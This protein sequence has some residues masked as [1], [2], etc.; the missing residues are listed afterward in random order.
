MLIYGGGT[1][2]IGNFLTNNKGDHKTNILTII[3]GCHWY[4]YAL[5]KGVLVSPYFKMQII[6]P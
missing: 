6:R 5:Y 4:K 1:T 3:R 2:T